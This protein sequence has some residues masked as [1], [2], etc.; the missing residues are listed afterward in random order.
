MNSMNSMNEINFEKDLR[1][2]GRNTPY[3][4]S[5]LN[6]ISTFSRLIDI[7]DGDTIVCVVPMLKHFYK[8]NVRLN[9]VDTCE[10][11]S[12]DAYLR[13]RAIKARDYLVKRLLNNNSQGIERKEIQQ[14]LEESVVSVYLHCYEFDKYGRL[15]ADVYI[16]DI[17]TES[18]SDELINKQLAHPYNGGKRA[19]TG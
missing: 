13:E 1:L 5:C 8:F 14:Q 6:G 18:I 2:H 4:S 3:I 16:N 11:K 19:P 15:L 12:K 10:M 17:S 9:G 7:I